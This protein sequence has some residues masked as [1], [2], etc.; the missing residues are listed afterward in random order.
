MGVLASAGI[1]AIVTALG[2]GVA[3]ADPVPAGPRPLAGVGSETTTPVVNALANDATA[4]AIGGVRQVAS[5][6]ATG[7]AQITTKD[8]AVNPN[9]TIPRPNGSSA[10]RAALIAQW[11]IAPP[12]GNDLDKCVQ[13]GRA[14]NLDLSASPVQLSYLPFA[15]ESISYAI[16]RTS[17]LP[18]NLTLAQLQGYFRCTNPN[19][20][21]G[22]YRAMLPQSGSGTRSFWITQ[23]YVGGVLP[24]PVPACVQ[25]GV[26]E[27][28]ATIEEHDGRQVN[29]FEIVPFSVAQWS[30]QTA[31]VIVPDVRGQTRLGQVNSTNP[32]STN[33]AIT[34]DVYTV[35]PTTQEAVA[36]WSTIFLGAGAQICNNTSDAI[37]QRFGLRL[38]AACGTVAGRTP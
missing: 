5:Y 24:N 3:Q 27:N 9:C 15:N 35:I 19:P 31:G 25:N 1:I 12:S 13:F 20:P 37:V 32:F 10:G 6:N 38:S 21:Q 2:G 11:Q 23:M 17:F 26:D 30:S 16:T 34:R 33:F 22:P 29:N 14:S 4:L 7:S 28:G 36:P 18:S 8:P